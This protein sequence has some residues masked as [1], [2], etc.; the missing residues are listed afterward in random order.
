MYDVIIFCLLISSLYITR[1]RIS[2]LTRHN[3]FNLSES[4]YDRVKNSISDNANSDNDS[5]SSSLCSIV[6]MM[7]V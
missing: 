6:D 4:L 1:I 2:S 5:D 3:V 7:K